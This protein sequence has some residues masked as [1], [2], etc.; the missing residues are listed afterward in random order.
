MT[1]SIRELTIKRV[2]LMTAAAIGLVGC[3]TSQQELI[4]KDRLQQAQAAYNQAATDREVQTYAQVPLNDAASSLKQAEAT[5]DFLDMEAQAYVAER[6]ARTALA[7]AEGKRAENQVQLL[8][9]ENTQALLRKREREAQMAR[10]EAAEKTQELAKV[11]KET[12]TA[13]AER[14]KALAETKEREAEQAKADAEIL[15]K[16][17]VATR[18][19][20]TETRTRE[21]E[22]ARKLAETKAQ[23]AQALAEAKT[24]EAE[25]VRAESEQFNRELLRGTAAGGPEQA[26]MLSESKAEN[27]KLVKALAELKAKQT[28][29]GVVLTLDDVLFAKAEQ[30]SPQARLSMAKLATFLGEHPNRNVLI[31]GH[32]DNVGSDT[33]NQA[34]SEKRAQEVKKLLTEQGIDER[35]ISAKGYGESRPA[36][37]N[38]T[39][40]GQQLNRRVEVIILD[41][42]VPLPSSQ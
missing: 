25:S 5:K 39:S 8:G 20:E 12:Q 1:S 18:V 27:A 4:A 15:T 7:I 26:R 35:R 14:L 23:Q 21:T 36:A 38:A 42:G 16:E 29:R 34:L 11:K 6:K 13:E 28:E 30:L 19:R 3:G 32:T 33:A 31:E 10:G 40:E 41:E 9:K 17:L 24:R 2:V 22:E 37:S